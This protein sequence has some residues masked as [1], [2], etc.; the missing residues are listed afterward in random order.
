MAIQIAKCRDNNIEKTDHLFY[1][2]FTGK[3]E[4]TLRRPVR[5]NPLFY[6][7]NTY[8]YIEKNAPPCIFERQN[9]SYFYPSPL[10]TMMTGISISTPLVPFFPENDSLDNLNQRRMNSSEE[11]D[12]ERPVS[13]I[14][15]VE[16]VPSEDATKPVSL[17]GCLSHKKKYLKT[18]AKKVQFDN[19]RDIRFVEDR[20]GIFEHTN[21]N[22]LWYNA[23]DYTDFKN[24]AI[25]DV[26]FYRLRY[27][28]HLNDIYIMKRVWCGTNYEECKYNNII[29]SITTFSRNNIVK[30]I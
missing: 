27:P 15:P 3:M 9:T 2:P 1:M 21:K 30:K 11:F 28:E 24:S 23:A 13:P 25:L 10:T 19:F 12:K 5:R 6:V 29:N 14:P 22:E 8:N 20:L 17:K 7:P 16:I 4:K 18:R 26:N